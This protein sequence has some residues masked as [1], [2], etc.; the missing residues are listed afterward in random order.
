MTER[1]RVDSIEMNTTLRFS[2]CGVWRRLAFS[3]VRSETFCNSSLSAASSEASGAFMPVTK[4]LTNG[5]REKERFWPTAL[6]KTESE[7]IM[8]AAAHEASAPTL[9]TGRPARSDSPERSL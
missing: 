2:V 6:G 3:R 9:K 5:S 1:A 8:R 7:I 4:T